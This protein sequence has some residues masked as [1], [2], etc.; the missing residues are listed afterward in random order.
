MIMDLILIK[1][2]KDYPC[3]CGSKKCVGYIVKSEFD[4]VLKSQERIN[5]TDNEK[6]FCKY[7]KSLF[8]KILRDVI[9]SFK[10]INILKKKNKVDVLYLGEKT[11]FNTKKIYY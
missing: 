10:I 8:W 5:H 3:R 7:K 9:R 6:F 1:I 4:G 2:T 11:K